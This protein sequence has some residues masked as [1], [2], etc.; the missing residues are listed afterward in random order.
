VRDNLGEL[1]CQPASPLLSEGQLVL[2]TEGDAGDLARQ[3][4]YAVAAGRTKHKHDACL[5][6]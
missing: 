2:A 5:T 1:A 6:Q 4:L 3:V